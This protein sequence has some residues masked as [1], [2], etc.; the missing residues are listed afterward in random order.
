MPYLKLY[1]VSD[2]DPV[3]HVQ[4]EK[5]APN[6]RAPPGVGPRVGAATAYHARGRAAPG[7]RPPPRSVS[8]VWL[9]RA[10]PA[11]TYSIY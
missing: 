1:I 6:P 3:Y 4:R 2:M 9:G 11:P 10:L 5:A 7:P 8:R